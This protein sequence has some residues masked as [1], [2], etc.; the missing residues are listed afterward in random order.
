MLQRFSPGPFLHFGTAIR[1]SACES[2]GHN[3]FPPELEVSMNV[4]GPTDVV[5]NPRIGYLSWM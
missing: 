3:L 2:D 5:S 4:G 1:E